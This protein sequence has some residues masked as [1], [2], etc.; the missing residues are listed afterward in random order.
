[1]AASTGTEADPHG[2]VW[3]LCR[4]A[5]EGSVRIEDVRLKEILDW[6]VD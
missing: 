2:G 5:A 3:P 1:M 4:T 6:N